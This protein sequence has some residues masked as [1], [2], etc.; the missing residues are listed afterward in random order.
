MT[1]FDPNSDDELALDGVDQVAVPETS[2]GKRWPMSTKAFDSLDELLATVWTDVG[3][4]FYS[5][6]APVKPLPY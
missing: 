3:R 2:T 4:C 5:R 1:D 6:D